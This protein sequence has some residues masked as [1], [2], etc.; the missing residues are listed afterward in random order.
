MNSGNLKIKVKLSD[1]QPTKKR[2]NKLERAS[3]SKIN[4]NISTSIDIRGK[5][6]EEAE[7]EVIKFIDEA[8]ASNLHTIDIIHGKG[9]GALKLMVKD[10]LKNHELVKNY[11]FAN[12][13]MGGDGVTIVELKD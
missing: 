11:N 12:I 4:Q 9:T 1:L 7:F 6:A 10:V 8:Y 13:D 5:R 2:K 3:Y